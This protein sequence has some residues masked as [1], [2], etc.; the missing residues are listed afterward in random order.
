MTMLRSRSAII[1]LVLLSV[2]GSA[3]AST[4]D[5]Y[6]RRVRSAQ[7]ISKELVDVVENKDT[8]MEEE[9]VAE[10]RSLV[11]RSEK[12][13]SSNGTIEVDNAW[14]AATLDE[15]AAETKESNRLSLLWSIDQRLGA[16]SE[17]VNELLLAEAAARSKDEDKQKLAEILQRP[18][19]QK[20]QPKEE[21]LFQKWWREFIDWL[22]RVFPRTSP[23]APS[24][25]NYD[26]LKIGMQVIIFAI[27]LGLI[28]FLLWRFAPLLSQ[29]F[30]R[31]E[32]STRQD[33]VILGEKI[34]ADESSADIFS[35][36]ERL[37]REGDHRGAIRKGYIA[38]LCE[39]GDRKIVRLAR[40]K[41]NR[42]YLRD[43][44]DRGELLQAMTGLTGNFER[45]WYGLRLAAAEDWD[46][47]RERCRRTI[48]SVG[49]AR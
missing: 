27:V 10:L 12:V 35:D 28:G 7:V 25:V 8:E 32:K 38:L 14:L 24:G 29:R 42:D 1:F 20:A 16:I 21:S 6:L 2:A 19:Y 15:L 23:D 36:A 43:V 45:S 49:R 30:R 44:R 40:H 26:S 41:T 37:A 48:S 11:P 31:R 5:D 33:R 46:E 17:S 39:L 18:E 4:L 13:D 47:F 34:G 22:A 3:A 9:K